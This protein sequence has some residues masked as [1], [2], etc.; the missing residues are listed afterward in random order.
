M[1][2]VTC[3]GCGNKSC[4]IHNVAWHEGMTC[5]EYDAEWRANQPAHAEANEASKATIA[6]RTKRCP[7]CE[8]PIEKDG[9][10]QHMT[11]K[12]HGRLIHYLC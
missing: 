2:I 6:S 7:A 11:C 10:C 9:G 5:D 3:V 4:Y 1:P 12:L 8:R